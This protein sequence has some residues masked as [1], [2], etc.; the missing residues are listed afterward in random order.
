MMFSTGDAKTAPVA[1]DA[2]QV[3]LELG[4]LLSLSSRLE[5]SGSRIIIGPDRSDGWSAVVHVA[6]SESAFAAAAAA[7]VVCKESLSSPRVVLLSLC[8]RFLGFL[9]PLKESGLTMAWGFSPAVCVCGF[10]I[11]LF[12][13]QS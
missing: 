13:T 12:V 8:L 10:W 4:W 3:G 5:I 11:R 2:R 7:A 9:S 6:S 1:S